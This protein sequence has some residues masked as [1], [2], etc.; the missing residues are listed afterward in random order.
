VGE[1][2]VRPT[3]QLSVVVASAWSVRD[4]ESCLDALTGQRRAQKFEIIVVDCCGASALEIIIAKH[5]DVIFIQY[6]EKTPLPVLWGAGIAR[7]RGEIIAITDATCR[8]G[9]DW[10][11]AMLKAHEAPHALIGGAVEV[12]ECRSGLDWAA[13][14]CEYGQF[15]RPL[16]KGAANELPGNNLSFKRWTLDIGE[17]FVRDGFWKTYWCRSLRNAGIELVAEPEV[18]VYCHRSYRLFPF[19]IRR[20]HHGRCFAGMRVAQATLLARA[21]YVAGSWLLPF[22]FFA[23]V[24]RMILSKRRLLGEFARAFPFTILAIVSW[25]LGEFCGYLAGAGKSCAKIY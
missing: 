14:F 22:L 8:A 17:E 7:A 19:L 10:I 23:R 2:T 3:Y 4:L 24:L 16:Q 1:L 21:G 9:P 25:A 12:A 13:Y 15:M 20:F 5:P 11:P 6:S 18:V